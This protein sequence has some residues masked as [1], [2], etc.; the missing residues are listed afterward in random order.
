MSFWHV[1]NLTQQSLISGLFPWDFKMPEISA[2]I[3]GDK[4][5]RQNW[6]QN[7]TT[8]HYFYTT[9]EAANPN[10]RPSKEN[11]PRAIHAFAV[12]Y[13]L[14]IPAERVQEAIEAMPIKPAWVER[15]L[16][17]NV[18]LIWILPRPIPVET[19]DFCHFILKKAVSWL[20]LALLPGL[21]EPAFT[22]PTRLLCNGGDWQATKYPA[23][24]ESILQ[25]F[26]VA[27][28]KEYRFKG[29]EGG[30]AIPLDI[31]EKALKKEYPA[32]VWPGDF[33]PDS[34]GPTFWITG[35]TS[36]MSAIVK[37]EGLITFAAH[38]T[39][40]FYS[41]NDLLGPEFVKQF[42]IESIAK[43]TQD[44]YWDGKRFW[45]QKETVYTSLDAPELSNY[46]RVQ[47][48]LSAKPGADGVST[49]DAAMDHIYNA[50]NVA[51]AAPFVFRPPGVIEFMGRKILNTYRNRAVSPS[52]EPATWPD[53]FPFLA[54]LLTSIFDPQLQ[55]NHFLAWWKHAYHAAIEQ[56]PMPGQNIFIMGPAGIGKTLL[57]REIVARSLG[58]HVDASDF[59][60]NGGA[61]NSELFE[62]PVWSVD[63]ETASES[64]TTRQ[65]FSA[66]LK[67]CTANHTFRHNR[68]F[69]V[70]AMVEWMGRIFCTTNL[71]YV[72]SRL[73][74]SM[75]NTS[76][77]KTS[78]FRCAQSVKLIFPHR[79][80][81][82]AMIISEL[83]GFLRWLL[84]WSPPDYVIPDVRFGFRSYHES[85]LLDKS[86]QGSRSAPFKELLIESLIEYFEFHPDKTEWRGSVTQVIRLL[87]TNPLNEHVLRTMRLEQTSRYL[88]AI[89]REG[90]IQCTVESGAMKQRLWIFSK[91]K[92]DK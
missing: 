61:F 44:I 4:K 86:Y 64:E 13:D 73:L 26:F 35:S 62:A 11:P 15:S 72:S 36:P 6:Y 25:A 57:N 1:Q 3:R 80:E 28:G 45:R 23:I 84:D 16:G 32:F 42:F 29:A 47:C 82:L 63:D 66:M 18:R 49:V 71:D 76:Q 9:I 50:G 75:D 19:Y 24:P 12:D 92:R 33:L 67:K 65:N 81:L 79:T 2:Q 38:A 37:P 53:D 27:C 87:H 5:T 74:G 21:D 85:S 8:S 34:Q 31:V 48:R 46:F 10:M 59:L 43:A 54:S 68:K 30:T 52:A 14:K 41:W 83:P 91:I 56:V 77:D 89:Q 55:M 39:K 69:E 60:I 88:E 17:G 70:A 90:L 40:P 58:G 22:S 20:N 51:G 78:L 7:V